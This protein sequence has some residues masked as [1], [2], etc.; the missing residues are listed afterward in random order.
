MKITKQTK[1]DELQNNQDYT[2]DKETLLYIIK[3]IDGFKNQK[4][5]L[6]KYGEE[7]VFKFNLNEHEHYYYHDDGGNI[8]ISYEVKTES[9][10]VDS[11]R[12]TL[13]VYDPKHDTKSGVDI[14]KSAYFYFCSYDKE[15]KKIVSHFMVDTKQLVDKLK[16]IRENLINYVNDAYDVVEYQEMATAHNYYVAPFILAMTPRQLKNYTQLRKK[17]CFI[18]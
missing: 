2:I 1:F 16:Y 17:T 12:I 5:M 3:R 10:T 13:E 15:Y 8:Q 18:Q 7:H 11:G 6:G 14:T 4:G 9:K